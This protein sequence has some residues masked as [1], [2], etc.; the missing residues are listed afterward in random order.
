MLSGLRIKIFTRSFDL[1]LYRRSSALC[2]GLGYPLVRLTDCSA[3]GYFY[4][5]L[6]ESDCD[7][8]INLDED[9]FLVDPVVLKDLIRTVIEGGYANAGCPDGGTPAVPRGGDPRVTN[10][11]F[12]ILDLRQI[13]PT[14]Q[15]SDMVRKDEDKEPYYP[16]FHWL[17]D[18]FTT[19]YLP[20]ERHPD[21]IS[22]VLK[23]PGGR[24]LC[25]HAWFARFYSMPGWVVRH[26]EHTSVDHKARIEALIDEAYAARGK[27]KAPFTA[28]DRLLFAGNDL[29]RWLIKV[30]QR[31]S[32]WP[33][34]IARH[35]RRRR[36]HAAGK[37]I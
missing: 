35:I 12:N 28:F 2:E 5:M 34:K 24:T 22:T 18:H 13:R 8:A 16:F 15:R 6:K 21:G 36:A 3:D 27:Q 10:P 26:W 20:A 33:Y 32:R 1:R 14:F 37:P 29:I 17:A 4:R 25:L 9:A 7:I 11:F 19:L 31:L 23:D 30:P